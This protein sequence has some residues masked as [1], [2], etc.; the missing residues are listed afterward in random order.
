MEDLQEGISRLRNLGWY[1][2]DASQLNVEGNEIKKKDDKPFVNMSGDKQPVL[3]LKAE[4][5]PLEKPEDV[6]DSGDSEQETV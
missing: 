4:D 6:A 5:K 2:P 3:R 1:I